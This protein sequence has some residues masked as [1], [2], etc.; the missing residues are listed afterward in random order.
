MASINIAL[1]GPAAAGKSTIAKRVATQLKMIYVD[2]GAMYRAL[3]YKYLKLNKTEDFEDLI[4]HTTLQLTY[5]PEKGQRILLDDEDVTD[6][7]R[8]NEVTSHVSYVASK[9]PIR[10]FA[11]K[12][13]Q[14]LAHQKGIVMDGRDIG[15]VVLPDAE[16]KVYM[17]AS[18]EERA[19]RRQKDNEQ[20][21]IESNIEQLKIDI[22]E[23]D[24]YDMNR[25]ISPLKKATD[26]ITLDTTGKSIEEV[27]DEIL[28][29]VD[30]IK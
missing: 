2:T 20:R 13:Q 24:Q 30:K 12:I 29:L 26:A 14:K 17:I 6:F 1:D 15:T 7:L 3:T 9:A 27:T 8:D 19:E 28:N 16:L 18:V 5:D 10:K 21:G 22:A 23:R 25:E 11:V 4:Q